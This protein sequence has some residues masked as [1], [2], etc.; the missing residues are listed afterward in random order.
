MEPGE[1]EK[2]ELAVV[3]PEIS[4]RTFRE[5]YERATFLVAAIAAL[6]FAPSS[7]FLFAY[8]DALQITGNPL[9]VQSSFSGTSLIDLFTKP[10]PGNLYR[11]LTL[12]SYW[13]TYW[14]FGL[15]PAPY[16][17]V[18]VL[19]HAI[20]SVFVVI[21]VDR[22]LGNRT[23]GFWAGLLFAVHPIHTEA[24]ANIIGR[25]ELLA[26]GFG[27]SSLLCL[28][29]SLEAGSRK[30]GFFFV[31]ATLLFLASAFSKESGFTV[32][33]IVPFIVF[34]HSVKHFLWDSIG[35]AALVA[36]PFAAISILAL[37]SRWV[38]LGE[39]FLIR[40]PTGSQVFWENPLL[41]FTLLERVTPALVK[42]GEYL[43][44]LLFPLHMSADYSRM[45]GAILEETYSFDGIVSLATLVLFICL[46]V[47]RRKSTHSIFGYWVVVTFL[48]T[49]NLFVM[50][51]TIMGERLAYL[52]SVGF[53]ALIAAFLQS[54]LRSKYFAIVLVCLCVAYAARTAIRLPVWRSSET[55]VMQTV[56]DAPHSPKAVY[57]HALFLFEEKKD[58]RAAQAGFERVL[59]FFPNHLLS[60]MCMADIAMEQGRFESM[61]HLYRRILAIDSDQPLIRSELSRYEEWRT[62][63]AAQPPA[64]INPE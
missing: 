8:D 27:I 10:T 20:N 18:N 11:P 13:F 63:Q 45:P 56:I 5:G 25:A 51:G 12:L 62:S 15:S 28:D 16:H 35:R 37:Y 31:S 61:A 32:I 39:K 17:L 57:N 41:H 3:R 53:V 55:V 2:E 1:L 24:V 29:R 58:F 36:T 14:T 33:L 26:A 7:F 47:I 6:L 60:L 52:P 50:S 30:R 48:L 43:R 59:E 4:L 40:P 19:L 23:I 42:F 34:R 49:A 46:L 44:L 38:V 21:L 22:I 9:I 54:T 64:P